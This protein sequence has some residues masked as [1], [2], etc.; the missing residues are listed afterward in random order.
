MSNVDP[1]STLVIVFVGSGFIS[2]ALCLYGLKRFKVP[3]AGAFAFAT[4]LVGFWSFATAAEYLATDLPAK[5]FWGNVEYPAIALLPVAWLAMAA[6]QATQGRLPRRS[7]LGALSVIPA[8]TVVFMCSGSNLGLMY[9]AAHL[10]TSGPV[11]VV[12]LLRGPWFWV[13]SGYSDILLLGA[14]AL[15]IGSAIGAGFAYRGQPLV[16]LAATLT[17]VVWSVFYQLG[18]VP[19]GSMDVTPVVASL[20]MAL[21]AWGL[22]RFRVFDVVPIAH[23]EAIR[24]MSDGV[25]VVDSRGFVADVNP[26]AEKMF[27]VFAS[28]SIGRPTSEVFLAWRQMVELC[29]GQAPRQAEFSLADGPVVRTYD[30][31]CS[32]LL[33]GRHHWIGQVIVFRDVTERQK[34]LA[35]LRALSLVDELTGLYNRRGFLTLAEQQ[36]KMARRMGMNLFLLFVDLDHMKWINDTLGHSEGD[37][38]LVEAANVLRNTFRE[39]DLVARIGGDEFAIF[40]LEASL[41]GVDASI[42]RLNQSLEERNRRGE[43]PYELSLSTG[44]AVWDPEVPAS[45]T[46]LLAE[47]DA[48]MYEQKRAKQTWEVVF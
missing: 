5:L 21:V 1:L 31:R 17:P 14:V 39:S 37:A 44:V 8:V 10:D 32:P 4:A 18:L 30:V 27:C 48:A 13:H 45:I 46:E 43:K 25:V 24:S 19:T 11:A 33:D 28:R 38:V 6:Q 26:A 29:Q 35:E 42:E 36:L 16:L 15:L 2:A 9:R 34:M 20:S 41:E 12:T 3:G 22:F 40:V 7:Q 23:D 47:A